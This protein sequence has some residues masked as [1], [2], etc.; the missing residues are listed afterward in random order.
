LCTS[1]TINYC[2]TKYGNNIENRYNRHTVIIPT[3]T[4]KKIIAR[5][6]DAGPKHAIAATGIIRMILKI[7]IVINESY[8]LNL[9]TAEPSVPT[10]K[11]GIVIFEA[12]Y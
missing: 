9:N 3:V 7:I 2:P 1:N 11:H 4:R 10:A 8:R 5:K 12:T 6:P